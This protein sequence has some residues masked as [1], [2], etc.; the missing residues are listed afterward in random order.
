MKDLQEEED[1]QYAV[2]VLEKE[3]QYLIEALDADKLWL[4]RVSLQLCDIMYHCIALSEWIHEAKSGADK[5]GK[6]F[7]LALA[8]IIESKRGNTL[9]P[10]QG[11]FSDSKQL[12]EIIAY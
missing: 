8:E 6:S 3:K 12:D 2:H 9:L 1:L 10:K 4:Q 11:I 7:A 5:I